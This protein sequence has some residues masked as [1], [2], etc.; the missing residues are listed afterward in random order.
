VTLERDVV[1][2]AC[3]VEIDRRIRALDEAQGTTPPRA[4]ASLRS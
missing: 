2:L 3:G 1:T 4:I